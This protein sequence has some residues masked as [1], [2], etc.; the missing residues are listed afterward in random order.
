MDTVQSESPSSN[1]SI[2]ISSSSSLCTTPPRSDNSHVSPSVVQE[3]LPTSFYLRLAMKVSRA[4]W[5][6]FLRRVFHYQNGS[7][8]DL[9]SNPFNS[10]TWMMSEL[11]ALFIQLTVITFTLAIS[12]DESPIWPVR[13]WI[14]GYD[15]GCLLSLMLLYGRFRQLDHDHGDIEQQHRG[16]EENR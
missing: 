7:T 12:K 16:T 1:I 11:I 14:T 4:R 6:I 9:G 8:S 3:R 13:L 2:T 10:S 5:F 15:I